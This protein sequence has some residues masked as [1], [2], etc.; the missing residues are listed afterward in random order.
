MRLAKS[1]GDVACDKCG[2]LI[3]HQDI[4]WCVIQPTIRTS[5]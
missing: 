5:R 1:G 4:D 3:Y 2:P